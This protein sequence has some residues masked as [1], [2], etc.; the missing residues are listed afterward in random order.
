MENFTT[1][2]SRYDD[3]VQLKNE[4]TA[5]PGL[6]EALVRFIS[7]N[8]NEPE[9]M[10]HKRLQGLTLFKETKL[11]TWGPDLSRLNLESISYYVTSGVKET[12]SWDELPEEIR[13]TAERLGVPQAERE[14]LGGAG[15]Q[16]DSNMAYHNLKKELEE[17]GVV[18]ENMDVA[19]QKYPELVKKYFMTSCIPV[20]D[21][22]FVMLHASVWSGGTFIYVPK[23][24]KV[25][26]P[27]QAYFR[28][29]ALQGGQFEHTLIIA[30]EDSQV[31]YI[32]GCFTKGNLISSNPDHKPIEELK[33]GDRVLTH[34][35]S[36]KKIKET[37]QLPYEGKLAKIFLTGR[38]GE[39]IEATEDHPFLYVNKKH[40]RERNK[41]WTIRWNFPKFFKK[42]DYL[43]IPIN[44][45]RIIKKYHEVEIKEWIGKKKGW[46]KI[47]KKIPSTEEFF[48]LAG[49]YLA[50]G[51]ISGGHYLNFSFGSH[52]KNL[53]EDVEK[54]LN[55]VFRVKT[56]RMYHKKNNGT[57]VVVCSTELC[58]IFEIFGKKA[59]LKQIPSWML[60][61]APEK[62]KFLIEG[63]FK[64][65][66]NYY[67]KR[68]KSG[69]LK[70]A[71]R[72]NSVSYILIK[73]C[74]DI[75]LRLSIPGFINSR[76]RSKEGRQTMYTLGV[77]GDHMIKFGK[78]VGIKVDDLV[79]GVRRGS[80]IGINQDFAFYP[81][82]KI[83][84]RT[85]KNEIVYNFSVKD[86][87]TYCVNGVAVHNCSSPLYSS[88]S[89]HAGCVEIHVLKG[90]RVRYSSV[91]NWSKT[92]YNLN[93]KRA[94]VH[95]NAL[96]EWINGNNGSCT[97]MLY[98]S[99]VLIGKN[100]RADFL[101]IAFA[102]EN[103]N[104]DTGSKVIHAA[105]NTSSR[106]I[107][108]SISKDGG[109]T[110]YRGLV[111]VNKKATGSKVR[112]QC[113]AL[114]ID[115][116]SKSNTYPSM[117]IENNDVEIAHEA[118]VGKIGEE[119]IFYLMSRGLS[120]E[121]AIQMVVSGFIEPIVKALPLEYAVELNKLIDYEMEGSVG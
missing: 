89:L 72:I 38:L 121:Q 106:I 98:P 79:N 26:A 1:D 4:F 83:E 39:I 17:Q 61:E 108:K 42:G 71:I 104:Q 8:K 84:S 19:V 47:K 44:K 67:N 77:T 37:Y 52:E 103:Q 35:G 93:T 68:V 13:K 88:G 41:S 91:E 73:Q 54:L 58:R 48:K 75:L 43:V 101:G 25:K 5:E 15:F 90:A 99:A 102:G 81:I 66:G 51:S 45:T 6:S 87:E 59:N 82:S 112:V 65:D 64:G 80:R 110:S 69:A 113:D 118:T 18:F 33:V 94:L 117:K 31:S 60:L 96:V 10:L 27:L 56:L 46:R 30:D 55:S 107:S 57:N 24:V 20:N 116:K 32:E 2:R 111:V 70:E 16:F 3:A 120:Q 53:I 115:E 92:V 95:E 28:M 49:Y 76:D 12:K 85:V 23:G 109:I 78:L 119:Q 62:Q 63:Y 97:T 21:H 40:K 100:A 36:Y 105:P 11:P 22:K 7:K 74:R 34:D 29:N 14:A 50:E 86:N 9:W 114:L